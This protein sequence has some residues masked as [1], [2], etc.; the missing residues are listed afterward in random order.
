MSFECNYSGL[1]L[2]SGEIKA[3]RQN[4]FLS[5]LVVFAVKVPPSGS[6]FFHEKGIKRAI[7][8]PRERKLSLS[9]TF[10]DWT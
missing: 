6:F 4:W 1:L 7:R 8:Y 5:I 2:N 9:H 10:P 3:L